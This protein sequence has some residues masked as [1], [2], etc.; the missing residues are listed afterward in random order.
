[1]ALQVTELPQ[2]LVPA[3]V[4]LHDSPAQRIIPTQL[5]RSQ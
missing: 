1:L 3:H 2:A 5:C 4:T